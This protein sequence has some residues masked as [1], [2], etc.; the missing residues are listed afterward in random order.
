MSAAS[1]RALEGRTL[2]NRYLVVAPLRHGPSTLTYRATDLRLGRDVEVEV[3]RSED[4]P[5]SP[6]SRALAID[7][8]LAA[9]IAHPSVVAPSDIGVLADGSPFVVFARPDSTTLAV[10]VLDHGPLDRADV[11]R[12]GV[13]LLSALAAAH[14]KHILHGAISPEAVTVAIRESVVV[15]AWL[16][17]FGILGRE[18]ELSAAALAR[19]AA[20]APELALDR[21]PTVASDLHA[22][23]YVLHVALTG[24]G[25]IAVHRELGLLTLAIPDDANASL[26]RVL[27]RALHPKPARRFAD[28]RAMLRALLA[29]RTAESARASAAARS[30]SLDD[31]PPTR[32]EGRGRRPALEVVRPRSERLRAHAAHGD[33]GERTVAAPAARRDAHGFSLAAATS[34]SRPFRDEWVAG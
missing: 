1:Q 18:D 19:R 20:A 5:A 30:A 26:L 24:R 33:R 12:V 21:C 29:L 27:R 31:P 25:P 2:A 32:R 15:G 3:T 28:A 13:E 8:Q 14:D 4:G 16:G 6:A 7:A 17:G 10:R 22:L 34:A 11:L 9:E 23:A